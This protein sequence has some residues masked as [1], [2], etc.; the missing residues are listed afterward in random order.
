M[1]LNIDVQRIIGFTNLSLTIPIYYP[2][3][4]VCPQGTFLYLS[5][6]RANSEASIPAITILQLSL[7]SR[8]TVMSSHVQARAELLLLDWV[9]FCHGKCEK[10]K[11]AD[12]KCSPLFDHLLGCPAPLHSSSNYVPGPNTSYSRSFVQFLH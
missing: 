8:A 10:T 5:P 6:L 1:I 4:V 2:H 3:Q 7:G 12:L 11:R 9:I